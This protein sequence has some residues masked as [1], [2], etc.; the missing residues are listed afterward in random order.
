MSA[1]TVG[2]GISFAIANGLIWLK[3]HIS[4]RSI[5]D[6]EKPI[7]NLRLPSHSD[8]TM[9]KPISWRNSVP[10]AMICNVQRLLT[11]VECLSNK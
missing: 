2:Y 11:D 3:N 8:A 10:Y 5:K 4:I 9:D 1:L 6:A 7:M